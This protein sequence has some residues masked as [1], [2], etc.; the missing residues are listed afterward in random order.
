MNK[1]VKKNKSLSIINKIAYHKYFIEKKFEAGICLQ[2]WEVK[3]LR[4]HKVNIT[5][6]YV[7]LKNNEAYLFGVQFQPIATIL[8]Y[9]NIEK[10][11]KL[12]LTKKELSSIHSLITKKGYTVVLLTL[13]WKN[14]WAKAEIGIAKGKKEYDHRYILKQKE[15]KINKERIIKKSKQNN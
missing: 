2:G 5:N 11:Q 9:S 4:C 14:I 10:N 3:S 13:F 6:S 1:K 8:K 7:L 15:W 12:L